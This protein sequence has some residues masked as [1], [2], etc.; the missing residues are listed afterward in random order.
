M[1][2]LNSI[3]LVAAIF[4]ASVSAAPTSDDFSRLEKNSAIAP[5]KPVYYNKGAS[6]F[7][8]SDLTASETNTDDIVTKSISNWLTKT[9]DINDNLRKSVNELFDNLTS[10]VEKVTSNSKDALTFINDTGRGMAHERTAVLAGDSSQPTELDNQSTAT[11]ATNH[12]VNR[13]SNNQIIQ[14][15]EKAIKLLSTS[16][17]H[18]NKRVSKQV[19]KK[20]IERAL[21]LLSGIS[22]K[23]RNHTTPEQILAALSSTTKP[24]LSDSKMATGA[25]STDA[26]TSTNAQVSAASLPPVDQPNGKPPS[27]EGNPPVFQDSQDFPK[28]RRQN[29]L[30]I[31]HP[32]QRPW[33][34][35]RKRP[36]LCG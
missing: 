26:E 12:R 9:T 6:K 30:L 32:L 21:A 3:F 15:I 18:K 5:I 29:C 23:L 20:K 19:N 36:I 4:L 35:R 25:H 16:P 1:L 14:R 22:D 27:N 31:L 24:G 33:N 2:R 17:K 28:Q 8:L 34:Q 7:S 10:N 11:H 13:A